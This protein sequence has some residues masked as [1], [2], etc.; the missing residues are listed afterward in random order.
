LIEPDHDLS[1]SRQCEL[2]TLARS[3]YYYEPHPETEENLALMRRIDE[4]HLE[5]P[6]YGSRR[7]TAVLRREGHRVNRKRIQRLMRV[8][9]LEAMY[10][11]PRTTVSGQ[12]HRRYPYLLANLSIERPDQ[13]WCSDITYVPLRHGFLYLVAVMDWMSR[14]VLSWELS[15]TLTTH[16]CVESLERALEAGRPEIFN[17]DQGAQFTSTAF[18]TVLEGRGIAISMDGKGRALDNVFIERLWRSLKYE[19]VYLHAYEDGLEA[20]AGIGRYLEFYNTRRPHQGLAYQTPWE[21][22]T[23]GREEAR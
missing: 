16:F 14:Y 15:N 11:H 6:F 8:M 22:Y 5:H 21:A 20:A 2:V 19:E 10:P 3:T 1:I 18:T 4:L 23:A 7:L 9:G 12:E 17:T 13:V